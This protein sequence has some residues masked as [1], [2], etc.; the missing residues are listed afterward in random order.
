MLAKKTG[1]PVKITARRNEV[2]LLGVQHECK[3][4]LKTG[5]KKAVARCGRGLLPLQLWRIWGYDAE[6][7]HPRIRRGR[8]VPRPHL[9]MD[10]YGVYTNTAPS[11]AFAV[12]ALPRWFGLTS[13]RWILSLMP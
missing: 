8:A 4:R 2:F 10:S 12:T 9:L 11:A 5:V 1:Q 3:V 7:D 6:L 13:R